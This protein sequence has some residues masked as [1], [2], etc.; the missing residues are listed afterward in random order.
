MGMQKVLSPLT[1]LRRLSKSSATMSKQPGPISPSEIAKLA[2]EPPAETDGFYLQQ[3]ML[4]IKDP[5]KS[6]PFYT[7]VLGMRLLKQKDLLKDKYSLF[8][9]G[10]KK[11]EEVPK[12]DHECFQYAITTHSVIQLT[13]YWGTE[14]DPNVSYHNGNK[15]PK[16]FGHISV[17]VPDLVAAC[18]RF[19][20][21]GVEFVKRH[22]EGNIHGLAFIKDPDGY[23]IEIFN[24]SNID[25]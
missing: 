13:H 1:I 22:D 11:A 16:G 20:K 2:R 19:D 23:H 25:L 17:V 10:F 21:L 8:L 15:D 5:R 14:D 7:N 12:D 24:P 9:M 4:R 6:L 3:A 18:K